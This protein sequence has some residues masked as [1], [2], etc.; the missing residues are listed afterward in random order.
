MYS[1]RASHVSKTVIWTSG[2][3][4]A[5]DWIEA[6]VIDDLGL[7]IQ[8]DGATPVPGVHFIGTPWLVDMG[9]ANLVGLER[10]A[11]ALVERMVA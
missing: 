7:P 1:Q 3:R 4:P 10:D 6:P 11:T 2:Y 9:S 5:F 8:A